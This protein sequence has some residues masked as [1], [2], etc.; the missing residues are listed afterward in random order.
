[1][2][3]T[4]RNGENVRDSKFAYRGRF[5]RNLHT[6]FHCSCTKYIPTNSTKEFLLLG[7]NALVKKIEMSMGIH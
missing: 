7:E 4:E 1:M 5:L 6:V 3:G 2:S